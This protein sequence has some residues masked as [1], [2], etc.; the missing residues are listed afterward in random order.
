MLPTVSP[1]TDKILPYPNI[2][3]EDGFDH[4]IG[5]VIGGATAGADPCS[6]GEGCSEGRVALDCR[7]DWYWWGRVGPTQ[8]LWS[9]FNAYSSSQPYII[10]V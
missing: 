9:S 10:Q 7:P 1:Q 5:D 3:R 8:A 2:N 6:D 4:V